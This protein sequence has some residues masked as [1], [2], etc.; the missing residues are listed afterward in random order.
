M[1]IKIK[2]NQ[3]GN[4]SRYL[5]DGGGLGLST[6]LFFSQLHFI[7]VSPHATRSLL[8]P[9]ISLGF[10]WELLNAQGSF[11][12]TIIPQRVHPQLRKSSS[13]ILSR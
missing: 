10:N 9:L 8:P 1:F 2:Y 5:R 4:S 13:Q 11:V 3:A 7:R 6:V 12:D